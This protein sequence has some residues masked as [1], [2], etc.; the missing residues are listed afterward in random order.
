[1]AA[2]YAV[3]CCVRARASG[4]KEAVHGRLG[5]E[6]TPSL[7]DAGLPLDEP[8][9]IEERARPMARDPVCGMDVDPLQPPAST[10]YRGVPYYFCSVTCKQEFLADPVSYVG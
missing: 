3:K 2:V 4:G 8:L 7:P 9:D 5:I 6:P 1:M 10:E